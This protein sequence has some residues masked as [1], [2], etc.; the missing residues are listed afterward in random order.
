MLRTL[1]FLTPKIGRRYFHPGYSQERK[2]ALPKCP[3]DIDCRYYKPV[4]G[5]KIQELQLK[6]DNLH[7]YNT[8]NVNFY[9]NLILE[10]RQQCTYFI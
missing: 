1:R 4:W 7:S 8:S 2:L 6:N 5:N 10:Q 3:S 9:S